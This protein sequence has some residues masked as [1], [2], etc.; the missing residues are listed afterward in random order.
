MDPLRPSRRGFLAA[1]AAAAVGAATN[2]PPAAADPGPAAWPPGPGQPLRP[3]AP[4][5]ELRGI[6]ARLDQDRIEATVRKLTTFGTRHT[7]SSQTDPQRGIGAARDWI[8]SQM[9][10]IAATSQGWMTA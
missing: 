8:L 7:L 9:R 5:A 6:L 2:A 3:Q 10:D 4:D 1:S